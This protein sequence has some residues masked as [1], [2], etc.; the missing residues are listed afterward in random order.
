MLGTVARAEIE[1]YCETTAYSFLTF[2][3]D[4]C[5]VVYNFEQLHFT[6][7][8]TKSAIHY[9]RLPNQVLVRSPP[10]TP[11][12]L[13]RLHTTNI[14]PSPTSQLYKSLRSLDFSPILHRNIGTTKRPSLSADCS[15]KHPFLS[16]VNLHPAFQIS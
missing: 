16:L 13:G 12:Q 2:D 5:I 15:S 10:P 11:L 6:L 4:C 3:A 8:R 9:S 1:S 14:V 7:L